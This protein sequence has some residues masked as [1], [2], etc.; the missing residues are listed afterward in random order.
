MMTCFNDLFR[1][2]VKF[3]S[4]AEPVRGVVKSR[5]ISGDY[6]DAALQDILKVICFSIGCQ[7]S[8]SGDT[9]MIE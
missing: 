3:T 5:L 4:D 2:G 8:F 7:Y 6:Q 9:V 1:Y